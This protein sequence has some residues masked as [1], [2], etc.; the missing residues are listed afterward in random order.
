MKRLFRV[1]TGINGGELVIGQVNE[2]F[3]QEF[4]D[5]DESDLIEALYNAE[6]DEDEYDGVEEE[7]EA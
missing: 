6:H 1:D 4:I 5:K 2:E 3:V 7:D